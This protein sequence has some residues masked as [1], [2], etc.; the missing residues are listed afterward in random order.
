[1][2]TIYIYSLI[3]EKPLKDEMIQYYLS[4]ENELA[5]S[6]SK[7][8]SSLTLYTGIATDSLPYHLR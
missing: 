7:A 5:E 8:L 4:N 2:L 3:L 1:M 6:Q